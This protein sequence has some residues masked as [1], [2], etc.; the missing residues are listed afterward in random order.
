MKTRK[1]TPMPRRRSASE[2][3]APFLQAVRLLAGAGRDLLPG[4][5]AVVAEALDRV[6]Q[7]RFH[8]HVPPRPAA[9]VP[10]P[11]VMYHESPELFLQLS[12]TEE[13]RCGGAPFLAAPGDLTLIQ[14]RVPHAERG[15]PGTKGNPFCFIVFC[16]HEAAMIVHVGG[17]DAAGRIQTHNRTLIYH[18]PE[19]TRGLV[20]LTD[21]LAAEPDGA[22]GKTGEG[23]LLAAIL[24]LLLRMF[25]Q[26]PGPEAALSGKVSLCRRLVT[27]RLHD[28]TLSAGSLAA[29]L[30]CSPAYLSH[31]FAT[32]TGMR[33]AEFINRERVQLAERLM[34]R[35]ELNLSAIAWAC[36]YRQ[37]AYFSRVFRR[38]TGTTPKHRRHTLL[39]TTADPKG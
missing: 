10:G 4:V 17:A 30:A 29:A 21:R 35:P 23:P 34:L 16:F 19:L 18:R 39:A 7:G 20:F 31:L 33:L 38:H 6:K 36:G 11:E 27:A 32:E 26:A 14:P 12:S 1:H 28:P 37:P 15:W 8:L 9:I 25:E 5:R 2:P 13:F 24:H 22:A 3:P